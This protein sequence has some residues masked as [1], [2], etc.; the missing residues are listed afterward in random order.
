MEKLLVAPV[1]GR[2]LKYILLGL[3]ADLNWSLPCGGV[4]WNTVLSD[5][6]KSADQSLPCGG[7]DWNAQDCC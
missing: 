7:V 5:A 6:I 2:G 1:W 4:D 3:N